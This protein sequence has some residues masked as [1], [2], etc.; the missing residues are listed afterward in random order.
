MKAL[1]LTVIGILNFAIYFCKALDTPFR[2]IDKTLKKIIEFCEG[3]KDVI[4]SKLD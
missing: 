2:L 1:G 4:E 3:F